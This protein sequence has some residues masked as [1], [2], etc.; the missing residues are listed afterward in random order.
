MIRLLTVACLCA[1]SLQI[2]IWSGLVSGWT[3]LVASSLG[4]AATKLERATEPRSALT[5]PTD[6]L[7]RDVAAAGE[8]IRKL[9]EAWRETSAAQSARAVA[10]LAAAREE[11]RTLTARHREAEKKVSDAVEKQ[12]QERARAEALDRDLA[13][14]HQE[15]QTLKVRQSDG[16]QQV[17]AAEQQLLV[18]KGARVLAQER[19]RAEALDRDLA[20]TGQEIQT[21]ETRQ[22][23]GAQQVSAVEQQLAQE[24]S[25]AEALDRDLAA[26]R[27]EIQTLKVRQSDGAQQ[28]SA[29]EQQSLAQEGA[30]AEALDHDLAAARQEI[31]TLKVRQS[32]G[33]QQVSAAEQKLAQERARAEALDRDL[34]AA[35]QEIQT[36]KVDQANAAQDAS[37]GE[38]TRAR[39]RARGEALAGNLAAVHEENRTTVRADA[40][41]D[42][43]SVL[44]PEFPRNENDE[45]ALR[46]SNDPGPT[47]QAMAA[48]VPSANTLAAVQQSGTPSEAE[49]HDAHVIPGDAI[50]HLDP[51]EIASSLR[52][53][54]ALIASGDLAAARLVLRRAAD[55]GDARAA[56]TLAETYDPAILEKLGV[57]GVVP[58]LAMARGWYE[59]AKK[60]GAMEATQRLELLASKQH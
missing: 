53:G 8:E 48:A 59:K 54:D 2:A 35:R 21:L 51:N 52:R 15:I 30:R 47:S 43:T 39:E 33:A 4:D 29:A 45:S 40:V 24:R 49:T 46:N 38:R 18:Q 27:Q 14:A 11:T 60:F 23:D 6:P 20:A 50:N 31:Q 32:D 19:A 57:H 7:N 36:L 3:T 1:A 55:A 25:R 41:A 22:S 10:D 26:A 5:S 42:N 37:A 28:V 44:R 58:D 12:A 16:A 56:M 17:S 9:K 34:A 13:A